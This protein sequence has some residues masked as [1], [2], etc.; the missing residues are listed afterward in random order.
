MIGIL[1]MVELSIGDIFKLIN[2]NKEWIFSGVG[3]VAAVYVFKLLK[4]LKFILYDVKRKSVSEFISNV[5]DKG[6]RK[7][8]ELA[9]VLRVDEVVKRTYCNYSD[10]L[11]VQ[12][13]S[14]VSNDNVA[15]N[16]YD[17]IVLLLGHPKDDDKEIQHVGTYPEIG[18]SQETNDGTQIDIVYRDYTSFLF[19]ACAG[20]PYEN[21]IIVNSKLLHGHKGYYVWLD[22]ITKNILID[23]DFL[24]RQFNTKIGIEKSVYMTEREHGTNNYDLIR[25]GYYYITSLLQQREIVKMAKVLMQKD[26]VKLSNVFYLSDLIDNKEIRDDFKKIIKKLKRINVGNNNIEP[27][28]IDNIVKYIKGG[29]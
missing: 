10:Y 24:F 4:H 7:D 29:G 12:Y 6:I 16:D 19:A 27:S 28:M 5:K 21:S 17:F 3:I 14:S 18:E 2:N 23:R 20:M 1:Y 25:A 9:K 26:I 8:C 15:P 22:N 13:G 11:L